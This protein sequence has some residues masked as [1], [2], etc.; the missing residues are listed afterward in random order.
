VQDAAVVVD[1]P[2]GRYRLTASE[3]GLS[4]VAPAGRS[5]GS[6]PRRPASPSARRHAERAGRALAEYFAGSRRGFDD[7]ALDLSGGTPFQQ[8][9]WRALCGVPF[10]TTLSYGELARR[11]GS[12]RAA[13]AVGTANG[14]NPLAIVVPCHRIVGAGGGLVGYSHG[15]ERKR[16]LLEHEA[17]QRPSRQATSKSSCRDSPRAHS[18]RRASAPASI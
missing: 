1:T 2:I 8:R 7:L 5:D 6:G 17:R 3:R 11:L 15:L 18:R 10:G 13:R 16:W 4:E 14:R 9:V 12:P